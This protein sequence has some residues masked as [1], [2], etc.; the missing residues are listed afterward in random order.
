MQWLLSIVIGIFVLLIALHLIIGIFL[1]DI[2]IPSN[3]FGSQQL[4]ELS[5]NLL[6]SSATHSLSGNER[7]GGLGN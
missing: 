7:E 5:T 4:M 2:H 1:F 6:V 3:D